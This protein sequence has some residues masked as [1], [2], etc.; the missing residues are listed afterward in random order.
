MV[1]HVITR[2]ALHDRVWAEPVRNVT[3][4]FGVSDVGPW[5]AQR[6]KLILRSELVTGVSVV[7]RSCW[8]LGT[9]NALPSQDWV[10]KPIG[11]T[12]VA[13]VLFQRAQRS[14]PRPLLSTSSC[15]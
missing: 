7:N 11:R 3:Q 12:I 5:G 4:D 13:K 9:N 14:R 6:V 2:Q 8:R 1:H 10:R 15:R